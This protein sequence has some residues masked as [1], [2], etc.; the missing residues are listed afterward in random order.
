MKTSWTH[1]LIVFL[2][3]VILSYSVI[4]G[5]SDDEDEFEIIVSDQ[6]ANES[7]FNESFNIYESLLLYFLLLKFDIFLSESRQK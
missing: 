3:S 1:S 7:S 2:L 4:T 5:V 6:S